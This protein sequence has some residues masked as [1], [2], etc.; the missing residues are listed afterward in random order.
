MFVGVFA[1]AKQVIFMKVPKE[2][3]RYCPSCKK[4]TPMTASLMKQR[5]RNSTRPLSRGSK[6]RVRGRGQRRGAGNLGR[7]SK[8]TKPKMSGKKLTKKIVV[9]FVCKEC[10]KIHQARGVRTKKI[11]MV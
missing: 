6:I 1:L 11:E 2:I 7:Y 9:K 4:H 10:K 5:A 3:K 8:P